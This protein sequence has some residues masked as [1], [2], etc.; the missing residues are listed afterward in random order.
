[1]WPRMP[2]RRRR[3]SPEEVPVEINTEKKTVL[4]WYGS[5]MELRQRNY[6]GGVRTDD[7][8]T[9]MLRNQQLPLLQYQKERES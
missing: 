5:D 3:P 4:S 2:R 8:V 7:V 1:M 9:T 6:E